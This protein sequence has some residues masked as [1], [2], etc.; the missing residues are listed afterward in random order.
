MAHRT[1]SKAPTPPV[2]PGGFLSWWRRSARVATTAGLVVLLVL[3][4]AGAILLHRY[5]SAVRREN[6]LAPGSRG[7]QEFSG[8]LNFL[9]LGS[10][11]RNDN[12]TAG[13]RSDTIIVAHVPRGLNKLY[14]VSVPRDLLVTIPPSPALNFA[15]DTTKINA[16]FEYGHG[17]EGG[18]QLVSATLTQLVGIQFSGAASINFDGLRGAVDVLGGVDMCVDQRVVSIHTRAVFEP[19]CRLMTSAEVLDYLR[20]RMQ[21]A[22]GDYTR[23]RHQQQFLRAV[24]ARAEATGVR[25]N[26]AKLDALVRAVGSALTVD[27]GST[28]L[29]DIVFGLRG[30][31]PKTM[32]GVT[33]PSDVASIDQVSYIVARSDADGLYTAL[34]D[35]T[36]EGWTSGHSEWVNRI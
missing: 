24:L 27:T 31:S 35:D 20:Q 16:A 15:G 9:L 25:N 19:G 22:D 6:L 33:I 7:S 1:I 8:P 18:A 29:A 12:P 32:V 3:G 30:I 36:L 21:Y 23:Q 13:E 10:D 5:E 26:P 17:G 4:V 34:R 14:L 28:G 11:L 2:P